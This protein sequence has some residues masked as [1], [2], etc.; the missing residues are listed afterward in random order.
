[1]KHRPLGST[2]ITVSEIGL[3][4]WQLANPTWGTS[5]P[6]EALRVVQAALD[7]GCTFFDTAPGYAEGRSEELLGRALQPV[8]QSVAI[9][10]KFGHTADGAT[11]FRVAAVRGSIEASLRRL[12][13]DYLDVLLVHNPPAELLDGTRTSL[14]DELERLKGEG[15]L[16]SYGVSIDSAADLAQVVGTTRSGVAEVLFNAFHQEPQAAFAAAQ[17]RGVGLIVKVPLDSGWLSGKYR[18][19]S[20]FS[21]VRD[22]WTPEVIA[23]RA[24]L[25]EQFAALLPPGLPLAEAALQFVLA[26]P[27]V[28]TVIPGAKTP[29]QARANFAAAHDDLLPEVV[30]SIRTLWERELEAAPLPW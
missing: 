28:A 29:A 8:R 2:G 10:S 24:A 17:D 1:M 16:R 30:Q 27:E 9:C 7:E 4:S 5:D 19:D 3:G 18:R 22:R 26:Q 23:R 25:V 14:Y 21:G 6:A 13:T 20:R 12:R 15:K 11:D